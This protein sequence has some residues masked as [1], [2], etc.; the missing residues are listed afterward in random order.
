[1]YIAGGQY[2]GQYG[3]QLVRSIRAA[4]RPTIHWHYCHSKYIGT[5]VIQNTLALLPRANKSIFSILLVIGA[6]CVL[7]F[8]VIQ[9][10]FIGCFIL[11]NDNVF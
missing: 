2:G 9:C 10:H 7:S 11:Q 6:W 1:M 8:I 4:S 3:D 5:I